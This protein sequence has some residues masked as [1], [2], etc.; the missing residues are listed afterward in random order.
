MCYDIVILSSFYR[1]HTDNLVNLLDD[2]EGSLDDDFDKIGNS[3]SALTSGILFG[4]PFSFNLMKACSESAILFAGELAN[5]L[6]AM[7]LLK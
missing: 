6:I 2:G 5:S 1:K 3:V 4:F 7:C